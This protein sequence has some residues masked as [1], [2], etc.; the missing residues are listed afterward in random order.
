M[1][2]MGLNKTVWIL[3][4]EKDQSSLILLSPQVHL[5]AP[6]LPGVAPKDRGEMPGC[7]CV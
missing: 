1:V 6:L 4:A 3:G 2:S 7:L 5:L